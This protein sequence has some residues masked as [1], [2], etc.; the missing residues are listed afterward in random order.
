MNWP[1]TGEPLNPCGES[2]WGG[3]KVHVRG[4]NRRSDRHQLPADELRPRRIGHRPRRAGGRKFN[5]NEYEFFPRGSWRA[6]GEPAL[7]YGIRYSNYSAP[8]QTNGVQAS[9]APGIDSYF[10]DR[11]GGRALGIPANGLYD[12]P[13]G[14]ATASSS[15]ARRSTHSIV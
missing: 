13:F 6:T 10:A 5:T 7:D 4:R 8:Y 11:N 12:L 15:E 9:P 3:R 2:G 14:K 1:G